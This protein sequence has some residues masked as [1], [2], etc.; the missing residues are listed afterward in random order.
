MT[1]MKKIDKGF[2]AVFALD[3]LKDFDFSAAWD[4]CICVDDAT[5]ISDALTERQRCEIAVRTY[6]VAKLHERDK[7]ASGILIGLLTELSTLTSLPVTRKD[8][9]ML[10][11]GYCAGHLDNET[12]QEKRYVI[13]V[14]IKGLMYLLLKKTKHEKLHIK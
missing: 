12:D 13:D 1:K 11:A 6:A 8:A 4:G 3:G 5:F 2:E 9:L 14:Y 7:N 10:L